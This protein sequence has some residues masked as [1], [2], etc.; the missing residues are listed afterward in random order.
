MRQYYDGGSGR[1]SHLP[2][3]EVAQGNLQRRE[4]LVAFESDVTAMFGPGFLSRIGAGAGNAPGH[5]LRAT[6]ADGRRALFAIELRR[7][8]QRAGGRI[9]HGIVTGHFGPR[10]F[11]TAIVYDDEGWAPRWSPT[12]WATARAFAA[13]A[14]RSGSPSASR[15][16]AA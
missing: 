15:A 8:F 10:G 11:E 5:L 13:T 1:D 4:R 14:T 12:H 3:G 9:R 16:R 2:S 6:A 7:R